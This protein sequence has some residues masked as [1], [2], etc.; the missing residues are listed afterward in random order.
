[1]ACF[2][3]RGRWGRGVTVLAIVLVLGTFVSVLPGYYAG[4]YLRDEYQTAML[5]LDAYASASDAVLLVS[6][7]RYPLFMYYYHRRFAEGDGP[8]VYWLPQH[9]AEFAPGNVDVELA[10][11]AERHQR[12]WLASFERS[13]QDPND[14]VRA[15]LDDRRR[16]VLHV[17]QAHNFL[18]LYDV[19]GEEPTVDVTSLRPLQRSD[20]SLGEGV[21]LGYDL[22]VEESRPGDVLMPG[23]YVQSEDALDLV[24]E[25]VRQDGAVVERQL[26]RSPGEG[27]ARL[28]PAFR[29]YEY[30]APGRYWLQVRAGEGQTQVRLPGGRVT[31]SRRLPAHKVAVQQAA[32]LAEGRVEFLGYG[33]SPLGVVRAGETLTVDLYFEARERLTKDYTVFVHLLGPY[34]ATTGGPVWAQDDSYPLGGGHPTSR[35]LPG[36]AVPDQHLLHVPPDAPAGAYQIE[37][38]LY[39][40][41]TAERVSVAGSPERRILLGDVQIEGGQ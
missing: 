33:L 4:R 15:W 23:L 8:Q 20:R 9:S 22:P 31:Q 16:P 21:L 32:D 11:L 30:T 41:S 38:G 6:G 35:W 18:R 28:V 19:G 27:V 10:P 12:L 39:D 34:N 17:T 40:A 29:V 14:L 37:I 5:T 24:V 3:Q 26:L 1:M 2:W 36:E 7:D 13:L 25:W